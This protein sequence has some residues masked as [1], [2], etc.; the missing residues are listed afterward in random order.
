MSRSTAW[1]M[2]FGLLTAA[3]V[4][5]QA[6]AQE[7]A[8]VRIA[9]I[10][11]INFLPTYIM[12]KRKLVEKHASRL[13]VANPRADWLNFAGGG[14]ATDALLAGTVDVVNA[15]PG[16][17]LLLW[18][19]TRGGVK[20]L[21]SNSALPA[22]LITRNPNV[23][24]IRDLGPSDKIA[25]PTVRVSTQAILLEMAAEKE[26]GAAEWSR[27][28]ANTV[29]LGHSDAYLS[30]MNPNHEVTSHFA[31]PPFISRDLKNVP[32]AHVV[33]TSSEVVGSP[34]SSAI[35]FT[36]GSFADANPRLAKAIILASG[37]AIE[38][39]RADPE[40][41]ARD[42]LET[43][44]D[45]MAAEELV[46]LLRDPAM[47]F[48]IKPEGTLK[49]AEFLH[50]IGAIRTKPDAWTDYFLPISADLNGN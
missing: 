34:L 16:N 19:R 41:A 3:L 47:V 18:D 29:Q 50:R 2:A 39:I 38:L 14:G 10:Q 32:G 48:D 44:N 35:M 43:A 15:G 31:T 25:V 8:L 36:K 17:M 26:F 28:D 13:G 27:L 30:L 40:Q 9:R 11:G 37:E 46:E 4:S 42:Y 33:L 21:V 12:E 20:G 24:S 7:Q 6:P 49:F 1:S 23:R 22:V 5:M 45:R